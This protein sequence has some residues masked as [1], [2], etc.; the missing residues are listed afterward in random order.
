MRVIQDSDDEFDG[1]LEDAAPAAPDASAARQGLA[2][3]VLS[4]PGT[5]STGKSKSTSHPTWRLTTVSE[6][7]KRA[8]AEAHRNH[9][10]SP[11]THSDALLLDE[12]QS[13][14]SLPD[15]DTKRR[16]TFAEASPQKSSSTGSAKKVPITYG[17]PSKTGPRSPFR[18][19]VDSETALKATQNSTELAFDKLWDLPGTLRQDY[20]LHDPN[21]MFPEPSS[22]IPNATFTQ[23][24]ML[25]NIVVPPLLGAI[26]EADAPL[27]QPP[28]EASVPWSD[29]MK[30]SP[31]GTAEQSDPVNSRAEPDMG[32]VPPQQSPEQTKESLSSQR[33]RRSSSVQLVVSPLSHE[34]LV[35]NINPVD[36]TLPPQPAFPSQDS[37]IQPIAPKGAHHDAAKKNEY[38]SQPKRSRIN[39]LPA[40][41]NNVVAIDLPPEQYVP[42][43]SRSRSQKV[44]TEEPIDYSIQPER[45][46]KMSKRRKTTTATAATRSM[47]AV[48]LLSTPQK[49]RQ[50]CD[51]GFTPTSTGRAL[52]QLNGD[53]TQTI[54]WLISNGMGEDELAQP[55]TPRRRPFSKVSGIDRA[56][57]SKD[58]QGVTISDNQ[59]VA[60]P[61]ERNLVTDTPIKPPSTNAISTDSKR[62]TIHIKKDNIKSPK[63]QVVIP[64]KSPKSKPEQ[65][66]ADPA[67]PA[68][69]NPKRRKT[70]SDI[71]EGETT[72]EST[73]VAEASTEKK[74]RGRPKKTKPVI[75][76]TDTATDV[77]QEMLPGQD[78]A[79][80]EVLQMIE[81]NA[82]DSAVSHRSGSHTSENVQNQ[83][84]ASSIQPTDPRPLGL[85]RTPEA[86][87]KPSPKP[88]SH[89]PAVKGNASYRVGLSKRARIAPL[90]RVVK[91]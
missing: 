65:Q 46:A 66:V 42:R 23:Q 12:P 89:S 53:V 52:D 24:R 74:K 27:Y 36:L 44:S 38:L 41:P 31:V 64:S 70:T 79:A 4:A 22:T 55:N 91:K 29:I 20:M 85:S 16:K 47:A 30:F 18:G 40:S 83:A 5:G 54:D 32:L 14:V 73:P 6:S 76:P 34:A 43:P 19:I 50:I 62:T 51:M 56:M 71:P 88:P 3:D 13:S 69:K 10:Q 17:K 90:L 15:H 2:E 81:P 7:L 45:A 72:F 61:Q 59:E 28:P 86:S 35:D 8:F 80:Y 68:N 75:L 67:K 78:S 39:S 9:L 11:P 1:D 48:D 84:H 82:M 87:S 60:A 26:S 58:D 33:S 21:L 63:V 57:A 25:E 37:V 49:V 77:A